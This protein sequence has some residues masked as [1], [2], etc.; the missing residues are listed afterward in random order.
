M[1]RNGSVVG[2]RVLLVTGPSGSVEILGQETRKEKGYGRHKKL[3]WPCSTVALC[4][5]LKRFLGL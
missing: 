5:L 2:I 1:K 4:F 3:A